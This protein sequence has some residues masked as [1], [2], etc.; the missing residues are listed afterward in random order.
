MVIELRSITTVTKSKYSEYLVEYDN[1]TLDVVLSGLKEEGT[2]EFFDCW[3]D[4]NS[5]E[6]FAHGVAAAIVL[7]ED[8]TVQVVH[9]E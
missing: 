5:P 9:A 6:D 3:D 1:E 7:L 2:W 4:V 8:K